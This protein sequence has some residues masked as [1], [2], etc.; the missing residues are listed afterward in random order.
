[1]VSAVLMLMQIVAPSLM[2]EPSGNW[3]VNYGHDQCLI[4][5]QF[6]D[7]TR[8]ITF[9]FQSVTGELTGDFF[10]IEKGEMH[11][12][13]TGRAKVILDTGTT[14][15]VRW[16]NT[17]ANDGTHV[18][19]IVPDEAF[20]SAL[21][22]ARSMQIKGTGKDD[23]TIPVIAISKVSAATKS[24]GDSLLRS[25]GADP[26]KMI[27]VS[28]TDANTWF[29]YTDYPPAALSAKQ[30]GRVQVLTTI[31]PSGKPATCRVVVSSGFPLLDNVTCKSIMMRAN[32]VI[33]T[34]P[35]R[36]FYRSVNWL[37][38]TT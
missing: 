1:V 19:R 22:S 31:S 15:P 21:T 5:R 3:T 10:L 30:Q 7:K 34:A 35:V 28:P 36:Y 17:P 32:F 33:A 13:T 38:P 12:N 8:S 23:F 11:Y 20:W 9:A 26:E 27:D 4:S 24:C 14:F 25:W 29:R 16:M 2:L 18:L 37:I 6:T